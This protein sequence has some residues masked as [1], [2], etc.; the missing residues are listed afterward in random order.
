MQS[1][2]GFQVES[3]YGPTKSLGVGRATPEVD[4]I[5]T[6]LYS[7]TFFGPMIQDKGREKQN[8]RNMSRGGHHKAATI[9][10]GQTSGDQQ[11]RSQSTE[12]EPKR[13]GRN[14]DKHTE[15]WF[16]GYTRC[17]KSTVVTWLGIGRRTSALQLPANSRF[18]VVRELLAH[19][20]K[21]KVGRD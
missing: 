9:R 7:Y 18:V 1:P 4:G 20:D 15:R 17:S 6:S 14:W 10:R 8:M 2:L 11:K 3:R 19:R 5:R 21:A 13:R 16:E 12:V